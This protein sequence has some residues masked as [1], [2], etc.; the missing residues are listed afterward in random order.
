MPPE[1]LAAMTQ[2]AEANVDMAELQAAASRV[3]SEVTGAEAG[4]VT[5]GAAAGLT[6]AAC[7]CLTGLDPAKMDR[8]PDTEGLPNEVIIPRM[9]RTSY[10]HALRAAGARLVEVGFNDRTVGCGVRGLEKWE[11][12][13]AIGPLTVALA[14]TATPDSGISLRE[15]ADVAEAHGLPVIVD[16]AAQLPP[17]ENLRRFINEGASLV[18]FSGGK[19]IRGPQA[20]GIL[21]G[22]RELV[23]AALLQQLDMDINKDTWAFPEE[24]MPAD[25]VYRLPHHGIGRGFKTGK[26]EIVG[27]IVALERFVDPA[28]RDEMKTRDQW[29]TEIAERLAEVPGVEVSLSSPG[30]G[31]APRNLELRFADADVLA[32]TRALKSGDPAIEVGEARISEGVLVIKSGALKDGDAPVIAD[33]IRVQLTV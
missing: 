19:G 26:E 12:E 20:S 30:T 5:S 28:F 16:A 2:A 29:L 10:D 32:L 6:L 24:L 1:V 25:R 22:R 33:R 27:L 15:L 21:C 8:L 11:I 14:Y 13:E 18:V 4:I 17:V 3:I 7:A 9:H 23:A 31:K